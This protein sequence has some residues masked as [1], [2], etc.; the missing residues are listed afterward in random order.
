MPPLTAHFRIS[1]KIFG[2]R[3]FRIELVRLCDHLHFLVRRDGKRSVKLPR[4]TATQI[5]ELI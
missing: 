5:A 4:G 1:L 2:Q 3:T